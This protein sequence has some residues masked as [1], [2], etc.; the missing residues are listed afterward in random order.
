MVETGG[1]FVEDAWVGRDVAV[2]SAV[3]R[4]AS[5]TPRCAALDLD[6]ATG[7]R[8]P[9]VLAALA[10]LATLRG[11]P[12]LGVDGHVLRPGLVHPGDPVVPAAVG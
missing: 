2:G 11:T 5:R 6:P 10:A 3:V 12:T 4:V 8:G 7:S 1:A 9:G